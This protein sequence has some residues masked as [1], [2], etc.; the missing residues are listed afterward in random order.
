MA[1][2]AA[3]PV[4]LSHGF[5]WRL[6]LRGEGSSFELEEYRGLAAPE[7]VLALVGHGAMM[8]EVCGLPASP[9]NNEAVSGL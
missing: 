3:R 8:S 5:A 6:E 4:A 2:I 7:V 1:A 9:H